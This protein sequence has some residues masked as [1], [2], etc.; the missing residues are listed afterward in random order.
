[1]PIPRFHVLS[2]AAAFLVLGIAT[3]GA[4][5]AERRPIRADA[6]WLNYGSNTMLRT[7]LEGVDGIEVLISDVWVPPNAS[8]PPHSHPGEELIYVIEGVAYHRE[9]GQPEK[10]YRAGDTLRIG[11]GKAHSPKTGD[12]PMR[13][14][15]VRI[16]RAG[17]PERYPVDPSVLG[18]EE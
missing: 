13:A 6:P 17:E 3:A 15:V 5:D 9:E 11:V 16:H 4:Q 2:L 12:E 10:V 7:T 18:L 1:M 14:I 8:L